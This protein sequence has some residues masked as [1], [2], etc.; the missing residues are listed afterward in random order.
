MKIH[1]K[2]L[3]KSRIEKYIGF[4]KHKMTDV[5]LCVGGKGLYQGNSYYITHYWKH[6]T[7]KH[8]LR[9]KPKE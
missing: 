4:G 6:V 2:G 5:P 7:C 3:A 8:C 9:L 1:K